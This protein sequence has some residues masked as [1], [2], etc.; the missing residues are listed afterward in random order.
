MAPE[1]RTEGP[2]V[3]AEP[4]AQDSEASVPAVAETAP[5]GDSPP[6]SEAAP[7]AEAAPEPPPEPIAEYYGAEVSAELRESPWNFEFFQAVRLL[8]RFAGGR[9]VGRFDNPPD[10]SARFAVN[11]SLVFPPSQIHSLQWQGEKQPK[12]TVN[13]MGLVGPLGVLPIVYSEWINERL[14][15]KDHTLR[16][17]LD[18]FHHRIISLFYQAWEKYRFP[19]A[20]ERDRDDRFTRYLLDFIG[21]GT[22][23]LRNRISAPDEALVYYTGLLGLQPRS[24]TA[25]RQILFDYFGV[26]VEIEQFVGT[27]KPVPQSDQTRTGDE[28]EYSEQLSLGAIAGDEVW[29]TQSTARIVLGPLTFEQY[30]DF[31]PIGTAYKVLCDLA[32]FYS[33]RE[34]DFE[35]QL[36]LKREETPGMPLHYEE[37]QPMLGWTTWLKSAPMT[38]DPGDAILQLG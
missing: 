34:I 12:M 29:D 4:P 37:G 6:E 1:S 14:R 15:A 2:D 35:V 5:E 20:F 16:E 8:E 10:E 13:F 3:G 28:R 11:S 24:A 30:L 19:V 17:F 23:G 27:W 9:P 21:L 38:R 32:D 26:P 33:R 7:D 36:V 31:L 22:G 18:I 25:M